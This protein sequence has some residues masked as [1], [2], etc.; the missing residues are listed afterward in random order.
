[1]TPFP[2]LAEASPKNRTAIFNEILGPTFAKSP[3]LIWRIENPYKKQS[4]FE[5][6]DVEDIIKWIEEGIEERLLLIASVINVGDRDLTGLARAL[7]IRW[8][9]RKDVS[10][11]LSA[12][13]GT[14]IWWGP[15]SGWLSEKL[16]LLEE[17]GKD[18]HPNIRRWAGKL[19][20]SYRK[21]IER[22]RIFEEE[23]H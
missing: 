9:D 7:L 3:S 13:F 5:K 10:S 23:D 20:E 8:G 21:Q 1:V 16:H 17:W 12:R 6:F 11:G 19:A 4:L 18:P 14:G 22:A 15:E 2:L